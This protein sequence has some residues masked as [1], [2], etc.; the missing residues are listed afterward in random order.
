MHTKVEHVKNGLIFTP[1]FSARHCFKAIDQEGK[2]QLD[3]RSLR[4][5]FKKVGHRPTKEEIVAI[6]RRL[7]FS[8]NCKISFQEF[9][10]GIL[11]TQIKI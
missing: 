7:D 9:C 11:P 2:K 5:F 10:E 4:L 3:F 1:G 8:G 6:I